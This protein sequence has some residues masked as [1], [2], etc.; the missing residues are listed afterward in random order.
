VGSEAEQAAWV[1][2]TLA[3]M[4][5][6]DKVGQLF[7]LDVFEADAD[8][9]LAAHAAVG[10]KPGGYMARPFAGATVKALYRRL[11]E[12]SD[13]PPLLAANLE[14][15]GDGIAT[16]G[17]NFGTPLEVA[18]TDDETFAYRL[19]L[20]AGREG[21]AVGCNWAFAPVIDIDYNFANP[22]TNTRTFGSDPDRVIR[23]ATAYMRG[24]HEAGLAVTVKHW[25]GDGVD[26]RDQHLVM[27]V[28]SLD[29][30]SWNETYGRVYRAL[31]DAGADSVMVGHIAMPAHTRRLNPAIADAD[32][33][34]ASLS[35][36]LVQ[37]L[38]REDLGFEGLVVTDATS[39][40][41]MT[42]A[43][44]RARALPQAITAGCDMILFALDLRR[45]FEC[46]LDA[47]RTGAL[48]EARLDEAVTTIL[49]FKARLGLHQPA[50]DESERSPDDE[51]AVLGCP[52]HV[53][54]ARE[55]ADRA[56]T[57]VK[58]TQHLLPLSPDR[59]RRVLLYVLG[60]EGG[61]M[62]TG[63]GALHRRLVELLSEAG[64]SIEVFDYSTV[65]GLDM[66]GRRSSMEDPVGRLDSYDLVLYF[67]GLK[68]ASNQTVVRITWSQPMGFDAP[69]FV[70]EIPT[71]FVSV[72]NPYHLQ[73]VPMV[74]TFI[75]GY[76][77]N[78]YV[79]EAIVAKLLGR[80][81]FFG[82]SP[83]DPFCGLWDASL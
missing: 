81:A 77:S 54:W 5:T 52:Q 56:V 25:P 40:A 10:I 21:R 41:G 64:F 58:D 6:Q 53:A 17:T 63:G 83:V 68:T 38:L 51:L 48:S 32:I 72:D 55:C 24:I 78:Q 1:Q 26:F 30:D 79:V 39:M 13:I 61:Y 67:A 49:A 70:H 82:K 8:R 80:S 50:V 75:N 31:I 14:R 42:S 27:T 3:S 74:K 20:V 73:D 15:G 45:D 47:V 35:P 18:A 62:D 29:V 46:V 71:V 66:W 33:M 2:A 57:L 69:K 43:M 23:M 65:A 60:D 28:N 34:P 11:A 37:G 44:L 9:I 19:G 4:S 76:G 12:E 22:I 59:H 7:C 36:E 16:D